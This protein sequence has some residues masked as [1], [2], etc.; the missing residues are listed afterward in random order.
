[1]PE[2]H[3][4]LIDDE[5]NWYVVPAVYADT[6]YAIMECDYDEVADEGWKQLDEWRVDN[7]HDVK[8]MWP[9]EA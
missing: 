7:P 6:F 4:L 5:G 1:M 9:I 2:L 3:Q 8:F